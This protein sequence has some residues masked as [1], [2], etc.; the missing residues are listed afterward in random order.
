MLQRNVRLVL[1]DHASQTAH[2]IPRDSTYYIGS[3]KVNND[4]MGNYLAAYTAAFG[5]MTTGDPIFVPANEG[6]GCAYSLQDSDY[7][8]KSLFQFLSDYLGSLV[9]RNEGYQDG[10]MDSLFLGDDE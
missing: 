1:P 10:V 9:M 6:F 4:Q 7:K 5:T 8:K 3:Q 2:S